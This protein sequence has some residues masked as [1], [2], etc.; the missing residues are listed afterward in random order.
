MRRSRWLSSSSDL[1]TL[2]DAAKK[3]RTHGVHP[4][5][6]HTVG[7]CAVAG[8]AQDCDDGRRERE[9]NDVGTED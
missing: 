2:T 9:M 8:L 3:P 4:G 7:G 1:G 6:G 5:A